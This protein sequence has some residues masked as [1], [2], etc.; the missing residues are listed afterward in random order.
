V[1]MVEDAGQIVDELGAHLER[2]PCPHV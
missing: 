1:T 2:D